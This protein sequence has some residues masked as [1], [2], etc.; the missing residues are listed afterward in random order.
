MNAI[1]HL[2]E[3]WW[4]LIFIF[5][6]TS[7]GSPQWAGITAIAD[8][9]AGRQLGF[10]NKALYQ[11]GRV[12]K[13]YPASFNDIT[14][15]TNSSV[16]FDS[17]N[18]PVNVTGFDAGIGWDATTGTGS[19]IASSLVDYLGQ[20]VSPGDGVAAIAT[21]KPKMHSEPIVTGRKNPH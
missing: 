16:Q 12:H 3:G 5:G 20:Y 10:L 4:W 13:A 2:I 7:A 8:Q 19:P 21:T 11:I 15:G 14:S 9:K 6:G 18:N 17:L 1:A